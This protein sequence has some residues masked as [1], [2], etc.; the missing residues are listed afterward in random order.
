ML[1]RILISALFILFIFNNNVA[2]SSL[3]TSYFLHLKAYDWQPISDVEK[4]LQYEKAK[5][6]TKRT[7]DQS[8]LADGHYSDGVNK[9]KKDDFSGAIKEF[10][11]ALKRYKRAKLSDNALNFIRV[12]MALC[13]AFTGNKKD[14]VASKRYL[15]LVT[16]KI[17]SELNW[18]YNIAIVKNKIG[19]QLEAT[20]ILN[21]IIHSVTKRNRI[22]SV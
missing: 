7:L 20:K 22:T 11:A 4:V 3:D 6:L 18:M 2:A 5:E 9:M 8:K 17:E 21:S 12:N 13:Y 15:D 19:E 1:K 16:S 10:K 14:A